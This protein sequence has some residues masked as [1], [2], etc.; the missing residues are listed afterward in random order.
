MSTGWIGSLVETYDACIDDPHT[1][2]D[3]IPL[4]PI[5]HMV[6]NAHVTVTISDGKFVSAEVVAKKEQ[7]TI[8]PCT[9]SSAA[10]T[11][12]PSPHP[13]DDKLGYLVPDLYKYIDKDDDSKDS[14]NSKDYKKYSGAFKKSHEM[15][16][17]LLRSW[18]EHDPSNMKLDSL[19]RYLSTGTLMQDLIDTG[20]LALTEK[21]VFSSKED[22]P[23]LKIFTEA[24]LDSLTEIFIRWAIHVPGDPC[25]DTWL[26]KDLRKSWIEY[27]SSQDNPT[28]LCYVTG[29]QVSLCEKHPSKIRNTG[30]GAKII[31]SNDTIGF[32]YRGRFENA[33]QACGVGFE[34]SQKMHAALRW[35]IGRQGYQRGDFCLVAW[36]INGETVRNPLDDPSEEL[37]FED[38]TVTAFTNDVAAEHL[39]K[40]LNGYNS[41]LIGKNVMILGLDSTVSNKGRLA[42][43]F[44]RTELGEELIGN[45]EAWHNS[46]SWIHRYVKV[47]Q[48]DGKSKRI[49]FV[50]S[51]CPKDIAQIAYGSNAD[52][53]I[54]ANAIKR[55]L[56]CIIDRGRIPYDIVES[57]VRRACNPVS[58]EEWEWNKALSI[59]CSVY[60]QYSGGKYEMVLEKERTTRDYLYGRLLAIADLMEE[61]ALKKAGESRQTN[62]VRLMQRFSEFPYTTWRTIELSL[63]P[64]EARLGKLASYYKGKMSEIMDLFNGDDFRNDSKLSGEFLLAYSCQREEQFRTK[65]NENEKEE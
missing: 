58:M 54:I 20:I 29:K 16:M 51:P 2:N 37:M 8:V 32:T 35:L 25:V 60:K 38:E 11:S 7:L 22:R 59:A 4:L 6:N 13:L 62:A 47:K 40:R 14:K 63:I 41:Q 34:S 52:D 23:D 27:V 31:S 10:R 17:E 3:K 57:V 30:D 19:Y 36:S 65:N 12:G 15:Y 43:I 24:K 48:E 39:N 21:G 46:G 56:P 44:F 45:L 50:G 64:Y 26:D 61:A 18:K 33:D 9:E 53:K 1:E 49:T 55:I 42:V 28:G 5:C